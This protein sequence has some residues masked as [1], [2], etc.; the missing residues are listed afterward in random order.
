MNYVHIVALLAVLQYFMFGALVGRARNKY[1]IK[2]PATSGHEMFERAFRVQMNTLE[3]MVGF[4]PV[5]LLAGAYWNN[6]IVAGI[7][8]VYL[9]GRFIYRQSY[10]ANPDSRTLGFLLT[11][12]PSA[13]L[14]VMAL[15]GALGLH[16]AG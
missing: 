1:G 9:I 10:V 5:L 14:L 6:A 3:Q 15:I 4:L 16:A 8:V 2:A 13:I 12:L 7:G 11:L